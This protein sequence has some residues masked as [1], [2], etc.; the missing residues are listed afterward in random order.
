MIT[1]PYLFSLA[2]SKAKPVQKRKLWSDQSMAGAVD[3]VVK[4]GKGL[5][6]SARFYG[7]PIETLRR[8]VNGSVEI[9]CKPGPA[10]I[11]TKE[12]EDKIYNYLVSM[13]DIGYGLTREMVMHLAY[14]LAEKLDKE[15]NFKGDKAGRW[16]FDGFRKRHPQLTIR[17]PQPLSYCRALCSNPD[18]L[19]NFFG[20]LGEVYGKLNLLTKPMQI[21]NCDETGVSIVHKPGKVLAQLGRRNVYSITSAERGKT[22]TIL[23]CVSAS[24]NVIPPMMVYPRK[25][26]VPDKLKVGAVH[27]TFFCVSESGWINADLWNGWIFSFRISLPPDQYC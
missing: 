6:E 10:T 4:N 26:A 16:W 9:D 3:S 15:H 14:I 8:R 17:T 18:I 19:S 1:L 21:F 13:A 7:V 20:K 25:R 5:R 12:E 2:M 23:S 27:D 24:G 11:F 22:H